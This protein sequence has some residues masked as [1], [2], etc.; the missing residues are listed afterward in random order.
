[1]AKVRIKAALWRNANAATMRSLSGQ[2]SAQV[3]VR[4]NKQRDDHDVARFFDLAARTKLPVPVPKGGRATGSFKVE[5][6]IEPMEGADPVPSTTLTLLN[7]GPNQKASSR[8]DNWNIVSQTPASAYPLWRPGRAFPAGETEQG[9]DDEFLLILRDEHDAFH[10]RWVKTTGADHL[11]ARLRAAM[12]GRSCGILW[13]EM[14]NTSNPTRADRI[15]RLLLKNHNVLLQGPPG[16][17]K[18]HLM[19]LVQERFEDPAIWLDT[20][21]EHDAISGG[22][23]PLVRWVTFHQAFGYEDFVVGLRPEPGSDKALSL[24]ATPGVL[25]ELTEHARRPGC[26]SLLLVDEINR[27]NVSRILGELITLMEGSKR[28]DPD[29]TVDRAV[30]TKL[31]FVTPEQP[32]RVALPDDPDHPVEV[33]DPFTLPKR[34]YLLASMNSVDKSVAPLDSAIRRRFH[35]E[36]LMPDLPLMA[37]HLGLGEGWRPSTELPAQPSQAAQIHQLALMLLANLNRGISHCLGSEFQL[38][39]WYLEPLTRAEDLDQATTALLNVWQA[40]LLPQLE[41]LFQGRDEQLAALLGFDKPSATL[42]GSKPLAWL[43]P[44][45]NL[46][47]KGAVPILMRQEVGPARTLAFLRKVAGIKTA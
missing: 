47:A 36:R 30:K 31:P 25:L 22:V 38:G 26:A 46:E 28:D 43:R 45:P 8:R 37:E 24:V 44:P 13:E 32:L 35:V 11:P 10:A 12:A 7:M 9:R 2:S 33:P 19:Q 20:T 40:R 21:E 5:V 29:A 6:P 27:G 17:G 39:Q 3:D 1:M 15:A 16:T 41:E 4:L 18:S 34:F 14:V 42:D 23:R